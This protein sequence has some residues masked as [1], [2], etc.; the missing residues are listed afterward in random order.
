MNFFNTSCRGT[1][2]SDHSLTDS[3]SGSQHQLSGSGTLL[4][5]VRKSPSMGPTMSTASDSSGSTGNNS[6]SNSH[7]ALSQIAND[8][9]GLLMSISGVLND[10]KQSRLQPRLDLGGMHVTAASVRKVKLAE[11][12]AYLKSITGVYERYQ[13][14]RMLGIERVTKGA[15]SL[16][17]ANAGTKVKSAGNSAVDSYSNLYELIHGQLPAA[18][19]VD[20]QRRRSLKSAMGSPSSP[21]LLESQSLSLV[22][23]VFFET[24]FNLENPRVFDQVTEHLSSLQQTVSSTSASTGGAVTDI[25]TNT[26]T[27]TLLQEKLSH[28]LDTVEVHLVKEISDRSADFFAAL[29]NLQALHSE[30]AASVEMINRLRTHL[31]RVAETHAVQ[32]LQAVRMKQRRYNLAHLHKTIKTVSEIRSAQPMIQVL[33]HQG[34]YTGALD[35]I[36][37]ANR[38]LTGSGSQQ[39]QQ[40][41]N[42]AGQPVIDLRGVRALT[43]FSSQLAEMS[44]TIA[45]LM[46]NDFVQLFTTDINNTLATLTRQ[47][48]SS[49]QDAVVEPPVAFL[50]S[51]APTSASPS[52]RTQ[53]VN[54]LMSL[55]ATS[56]STTPLPVPADAAVTALPDGGADQIDS[57][58][59]ALDALEHAGL[60]VATEQHPAL[61]DMHG[62]L[63]PL[64]LGLI[65]IGRLGTALQS[66]REI[67]AKEVKAVFKKH[68]ATLPGVTAA[69]ETPP[70][71]GNV[72]E[73]A[74]SK[75]QSS[76]TERAIRVLN[77]DNFL[78]LLVDVYLSVYELLKRM[79]VEQC[80]IACV[81]VDAKHKGIDVGRDQATTATGS[82]N[83]ARDD[84]AAKRPVRSMFQDDYEHKPTGN[85]AQLA[86]PPS[87]RL[88]ASVSITTSLNSVAASSDPSSP[89]NTAANQQ[90]TDSPYQQLWN[91]C[92]DALFQL[93]DLAHVRVAKLVAVRADQNAQLNPKDFHRLF[94]LTW[95]FLVE[96]EHLLTSV[97]GL[98]SALSCRDSAATAKMCYG[99]RG[100]M[101]AQAKAFMNHFH[102]EKTKQL[103]LLID[104]EQWIQADIPYDFQLLF[105]RIVAAATLDSFSIEDDNAAIPATLLSRRQADLGAATG[106]ELTVQTASTAPQAPPPPPS[107][108]IVIGFEPLER[109][110]STLPGSKRF[111]VVGCVLMFV[112]TLVDYLQCAVRIP[113]LSTEVLQKLCETF[114]LFNS[115]TCQ[116]ILGAG[117]MQSAGL[118]NITAKHLALAAQSVGAVG[119]LVPYVKSTL[120]NFVP[121]KH[122]VLLNDLDKVAKD[123]HEHQVE[124][125]NKLVSIMQERAIAHTKAIATTDWDAPAQ[126]GPNQEMLPSS[127]MEQLVKETTTLHKVLGK[128]LPIDIVKRVLGEIFICYG[129]K[130][131]DELKRLDIYTSVA[132]NRLLFDAQYYV[133]RMSALEGIDGPGNQL[134]VVVNNMRIKDKRSIFKTGPSTSPTPAPTSAAGATAAAA[135]AAATKADAEAKIG[136][137]FKNLM[138][139]SSKPTTVATSSDAQLPANA[140]PPSTVTGSASL[141]NMAGVSMSSSGTLPSGTTAQQQQ[142]QQQQQATSV[143]APVGAAAAAKDPA[144]AARD[145]ANKTKQMA[146]DWMKKAFMKGPGSDNPS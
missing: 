11:F 127:Y 82:H 55:K 125:Y 99:L 91:D 48:G 132:K 128:Y 41:Q 107:K 66:W 70:P 19:P 69:T 26:T 131:E 85:A 28:Y 44:R 31:A 37:E 77:F 105:D 35:L 136:F 123:L 145:A 30:T 40:E 117:A 3:V 4:A 111:Y 32:G 106:S 88:S 52:K 45:M 43:H 62:Q 9:R 50:K 67:M 115:R 29:A 104:N 135:A 81:L 59:L 2:T 86:P 71:A 90:S 23:Q 140:T 78:R 79:A 108:T 141:F 122:S 42:A 96:S 112:K 65:R 146:T 95:G 84:D 93:V 92:S 118:K 61:R 24:E 10:P 114:K 22:P 124:I 58:A 17:T 100:S 109:S 113:S 110:G 15:P 126:L 75:D 74:K 6:V 34:D 60:H 87:S 16:R 83:A 27:V 21:N 138:S 57:M 68:Y 13:Y 119:A 39:Q 46:Q 89:I 33:L 25:V 49:A 18:T 121:I 8:G 98:A 73:N 76:A 97:G 116:V 130:L 56:I 129:I 53:F 64:V 1:T 51:S 103:S 38:V 80:L 5:K 134:E 142:Q 144:A 143:P 72:R 101:V 120:S 102:M 137:N 139:S 94:G 20:Q 36:S 133:Q 12:D 63:T 14:H 7:T 47:L 54:R